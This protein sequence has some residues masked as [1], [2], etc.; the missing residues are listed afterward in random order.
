MQEDRNYYTKIAQACD[1]I[2][3]EHPVTSNDVVRYSSHLISP[4]TKRIPGNDPSL[5]AII[6]R[7][8]PDLVLVKTN[9]VSIIIPPERMGG[10]GI[11][12]QQNESFPGV[13][14]LQADADGEL[15]TVYSG[16]NFTRQP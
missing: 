8:H 2:L 10:F 3:S 1:L 9:F 13:W 7:L 11:I 15:E 5:P 14:Q 4:F 6:V 12:W 16:T